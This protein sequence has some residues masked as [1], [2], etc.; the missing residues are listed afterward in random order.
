[1]WHSAWG[2]VTDPAAIRL[3]HIVSAA[4]SLTLVVSA[5]R[6][7][8]ACPQCGCSSARVHS[9]Y[10]RCVA[11]LPWHG[12]AV[13][14]ELHTR[15]F[16]CMSEVCRRRIFCERLP[17]VVAASA[18]KTARLISALELIGFALGGEA[19]ARLARQLGLAVSPD[20]LDVPKNNSHFW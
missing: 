9:R 6:Q 14:L 13:R 17:S 2:H 1:M 11:D 7:S 15:R 20:T 10:T 18:R 19:G 8:A 3:S 4:K 16:F 5:G 12:I